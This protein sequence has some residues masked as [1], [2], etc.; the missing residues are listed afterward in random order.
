MGRKKQL[1]VTGSHITNYNLEVKSFNENGFQFQRLY[2]IIEVDGQEFYSYEICEDTRFTIEYLRNK[3]P[4]ELNFA[5][6]NFNRVEISEY[7][8]RD[9]LFFHVHHKDFRQMQVTGRRL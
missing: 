3:I 8:E 7:T 6:V 4:E 5:I 9:Y 1:N 2:L